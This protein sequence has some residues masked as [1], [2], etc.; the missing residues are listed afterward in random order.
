VSYHIVV[1]REWYIIFWTWWWCDSSG[2]RVVTPVYR[3]GNNLIAQAGVCLRHDGA[4]GR[5]RVI[6][7]Q[8]QAWH[9]LLGSVDLR[10]RA[11]PGQGEVPSYSPRGQSRPRLGLIALV[12]CPRAPSGVTSGGHLGLLIAPLSSF[13][14]PPCWLSLVSPCSACPSQRCLRQR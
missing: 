9:A 10:S 12:R 7:S 1:V 14:S 8:G 5:R 3:I 4:Q 11:A 6:C 2:Q 13:L